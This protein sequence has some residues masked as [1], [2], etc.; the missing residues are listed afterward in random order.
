MKTFL[1]QPH[2]LI[3]RDLFCLVLVAAVGLVFWREH[4][5]VAQHAAQ[6]SAQLERSH[7]EQ[8]CLQ[9][10]L[11]AT[12]D[13]LAEAQSELAALQPPILKRAEELK[14]IAIKSVHGRLGCG[15]GGEM[16]FVDRQGKVITAH[17]SLDAIHVFGAQVDITDMLTLLQAR[18]QS[19]KSRKLGPMSSRAE[20]LC[21]VICETLRIIK[22]PA[23]IPVMKDLVLTE[24][25]PR[26]QRDAAYHLVKMG[27]DES[28]REEIQR[29]QFP[30]DLK[31]YFAE[32][33]D[34]V[35]FEEKRP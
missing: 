15:V 4:Q 24:R 25:N 6:L 1:V 18:I 13:Q 2:Q 23:A 32:T 8:Q 14:E 17:C 20:S 27:E 16:K 30:M 12:R 22:H 9:A 7:A 21:Y 10:E 31:R 11:Q 28:L 5:K 33:P 34:W 3:L 19:N 29:I 26:I 35:A